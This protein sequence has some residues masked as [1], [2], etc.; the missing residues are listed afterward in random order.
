MLE[1]KQASNISHAK[2]IV[3]ITL[4]VDHDLS[5]VKHT[6]EWRHQAHG[7]YQLSSSRLKVQI[8]EISSV[9]GQATADG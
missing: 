7:Q 8:L 1:V 4:Y 2:G 9:D 3:K 6:T 5:E